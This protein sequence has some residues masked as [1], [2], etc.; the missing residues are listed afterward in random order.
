MASTEKEQ[1]LRSAMRQIAREEMDAASA[2]LGQSPLQHENIHEA[3]RRLKKLRALLRLLRNEIPATVFEKE[4]RTFRDIG[5]RLAPIRDARA[6]VSAAESLKKDSKKHCAG[7]SQVIAVLLKGEAALKTA[8]ARKRNSLHLL[9]LARPRVETWLSKKFTAD[10]LRDGVQETFRRGRKAFRKAEKNPGD[11]QLHTL[12]KR[13]KDLEHQFGLLQR[14]RL[15]PTR[16]PR[17]RITALG[18]CLG[19]DHDLASL[20]AGLKSHNLSL[21]PPAIKK[22]REEICRQRSRLQKR[23]FKLAEKIYR[24]PPGRFARRAI[25]FK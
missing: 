17:K 10:D 12:R 16:S 13:V 11:K 23:A 5:R 8:N 9:N 3:R 22:I 6:L 25:R 14:Q 19:K 2:E 1:T 15:C 21:K 20:S 18:D 24:E 4:N 7:L